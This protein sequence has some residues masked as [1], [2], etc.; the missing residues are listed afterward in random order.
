[1]VRLLW[2]G[3]IVSIH[4]VFVITM[5]HVSVLVAD[6]MRMFSTCGLEQSSH[7][8]IRGAD[9]NVSSSDFLP[10]YFRI[11]IVVLKY[12]CIFNN[13]KLFYVFTTNVKI[14]WQKLR[15]LWTRSPGQKALLTRLVPE[16]TE[17]LID[18]MTDEVFQSDFRGR[19]RRKRKLTEAEFCIYIYI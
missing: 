2:C 4:T 5:R 14:I 19:W 9:L 18:R 7:T 1:M 10:V 15:P 8:A 12:S 17:L 6:G 11:Q 16:R 3:D 13:L